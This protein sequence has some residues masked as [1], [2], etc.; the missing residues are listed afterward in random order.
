MSLF[1]K[2]LLRPEVFTIESNDS[3]KNAAKVMN[4]LGISC[5]IVITDGLPVGIITERDIMK[6]IMFSIANL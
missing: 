5:L 1:V 2:D 3:I 4:N 6:S